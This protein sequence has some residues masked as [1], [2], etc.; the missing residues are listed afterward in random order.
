M[1]ATR[2]RSALVMVGLALFSLALEMCSAFVPATTTGRLLA[3]EVFPRRMAQNAIAQMP[4]T[5]IEPVASPED[6]ERILD[7]GKREKQVL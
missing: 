4:T 5:H 2:A 3:T 6:F 7:A 1:E